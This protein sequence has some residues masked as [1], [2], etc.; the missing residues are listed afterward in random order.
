MFIY[1]VKFF[2]KICLSC[3]GVIKESRYLDVSIQFARQFRL[4]TSYE[5]NVLLGYK[6]RLAIY[7]STFRQDIT[8]PLLQ[9]CYLITNFQLVKY[10]FS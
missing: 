7:F 4:L 10:F 6:Y 8:V 3:T 2:S 5:E 1:Y 9:L